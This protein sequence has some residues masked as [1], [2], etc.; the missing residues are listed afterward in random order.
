MIAQVVV[1]GCS[2]METY[3]LGNGHIDLAQRIKINKKLGTPIAASLA[4]GGST[5]SRIL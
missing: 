5:N 1:N 2:Y 3:A 4:I